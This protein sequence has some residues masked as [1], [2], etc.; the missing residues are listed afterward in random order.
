MANL[1]FVAA[2]CLVLCAVLVCGQEKLA[3]P[4]EQE[5]KVAENE[6][7]KAALESLKRLSAGAA[8]TEFAEEIEHGQKFYEGSWK[9]PNGNIDALV[10]EAGDLVELEEVIVV[11][12]VPAAPR[13]EVEKEAGKDAKITW[14][15]KTYIMYEAHYK[16]DG[17][18]REV[19]L[20][21]DGRRHQEEGEME[22][23]EED[24]K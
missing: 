8:I 17:R 14:E 23:G 24:E 13:A 19:L 6:V 20:S 2:G 4:V 7:P 22:G 9:G 11:D 12:E 5:R 18:G 21:P 15:K 3:P 16:K 1:S 10:T